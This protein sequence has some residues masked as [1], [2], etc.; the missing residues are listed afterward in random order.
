MATIVAGIGTLF[1]SVVARGRTQSTLLFIG[2][3]EGI[4][5]VLGETHDGTHQQERLLV[6]ASTCTVERLLGG[7]RLGT[8]LFLG[9]DGAKED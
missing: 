9:H 5:R 1:L 2:G 7:A 6:G 4:C 8:R 3:F